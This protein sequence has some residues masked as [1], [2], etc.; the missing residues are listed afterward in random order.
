MPPAAKTVQSYLEELAPLR[1]KVLE[2]VRKVIL[3]HLDSDC[4]ESLHFG[5][6]SYAV[7][8]RVYPKGYHGNP[9]LPLPYAALEAQKSH[10]ALYLLAVVG[11]PEVEAWLRREW[12]SSGRKLD[13]AQGCIR[14]KKLEDLPLEL[15]GQ[16]LERVPVAAYIARYE[17]QLAEADEGEGGDEEDGDEEGDEEEGEDGEEDAGE[18]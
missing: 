2:A 10:Y 12:A 3:D 6:L 8:H 9:K 5:V 11:D 16:L 14:F 1:R 13:M 7:P 15:I 17:A 4:E 18:A